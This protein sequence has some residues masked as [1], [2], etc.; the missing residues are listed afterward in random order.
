LRYR[1]IV[2]PIVAD[3]R[4]VPGTRLGRQS[5]WIFNN[6]IGGGQA[7]FDQHIEDLS[8]RD[9]VMLYALFNQKAHVDELI[10]A[11]NKFLP[12]PQNFR[13]ATVVDIGCGPFTA[14]LAIANVVG[15][16]VAYRYFGVDRASSMRLFADDL[17]REVR[18]L[19]EFN[20]DTEVSF[21]ESVD[22]IDFGP[23][24]AAEITVFVLSYLLASN[25]IDVAELVGEITRASDRIGLGPAFVLYTNSARESARA[26]YPDF[27]DMMVA[28]GF[29][30]HI[31]ETERFLDTDSPRAIHYALFVR[32]P[33]ST[34]H[35][36][37]F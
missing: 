28:S 7:D 22:E 18:V 24:R 32:A 33:V 11:F 9:R 23:R 2:D 30:V 3:H 29:H 20:Q 34:L 6:A 4:S 37:Q 19:A 12:D 5:D 8:P 27:R 14:G 21:H 35:I 17:M 25:T 13:G 31:E 26:N 15:N 16:G 10:H 1:L 36:T